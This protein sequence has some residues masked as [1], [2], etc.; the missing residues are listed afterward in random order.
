MS[1]LITS[2]NAVYTLTL[3]ALFSA[4]IVLENWSSDRAFEQDALEMAETQMSIDGKLNKGYVP[5]PVNQN[6]SFSAASS[7]LDVFEAV[8]A[9]QQQERTIIDLGAT[10]VLPSVNRRY[11]FINGC[12][13]SGSVAPNAGG[14]LENRGFSLVWER[15]IPV[16]I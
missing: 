13:S 3:S 8:I 16:G 5:R 15:V 2:A 11:T 10:I 12:L 14:T 9:Y 6:L 1:N 7:S 4:P